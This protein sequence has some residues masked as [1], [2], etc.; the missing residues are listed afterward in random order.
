MTSSWRRRKRHH[1]GILTFLC[2]LVIAGIY[3]G[4]ILIH[5]GTIPVW[6]PIA[7]GNV[8]DTRIQ[9]EISEVTGV[10]RVTFRGDCRIRY[11]VAG[12]EY[13][14]W[15]DYV[16][17]SDDRNWTETMLSHQ[18]GKGFTVK[19]NPKNPAEGYVVPP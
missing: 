2:L 16:I 18:L 9:T 12:Q 10:S 6:W 1:V 8:V 4:Q 7:L 17:E 15:Q 3:G 19:Y 11:V 14:L 5:K 13:F